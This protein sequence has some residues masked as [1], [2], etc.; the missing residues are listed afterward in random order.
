MIKCIVDGKRDKENIELSGMGHIDST[1]L[2][3]IKSPQY[4]TK[5]IRLCFKETD[6]SKSILLMDVWSEPI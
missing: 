3:L 4:F 5:A 6:K 2:S 1:K